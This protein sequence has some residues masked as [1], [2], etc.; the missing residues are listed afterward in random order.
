M[1][2]PSEVGGVAGWELDTEQIK[3][4]NG[5]GRRQSQESSARDTTK[6]ARDG[7]GKKTQKREIEAGLEGG[8]NVDQHKEGG[9]GGGYGGWRWAARVNEDG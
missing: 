6:S 2:M 4:G 3:Q 8:S 1:M 9:G 5:D 7:E